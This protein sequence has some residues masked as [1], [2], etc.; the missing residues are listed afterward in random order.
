MKKRHLLTLVIPFVC[1]PLFSDDMPLNNDP[2][3]PPICDECPTESCPQPDPAM[4]CPVPCNRAITFEAGPRVCCGAD[5]F[6]T[7]D[8]LWWKAE[9]DGLAYA[10]T[11][12]SPQNATASV[13]KEGSVRHPDLGWEPGFRAGLGWNTC[14]DGWDLFAEYTWFQSNGNKDSVTNPADP[15]NQLVSYWGLGSSGIGNSTNLPPNFAISSANSDWTAHVNVIDL[16]LGRS[17]FVGEK[18]TFRPHAG[19]RGSWQSQQYNVTYNIDTTPTDRITYKMDQ[20]QDFWG[21]GLKF[22]LDTYWLFCRTFGLVADFSFSVLSSN[23]DVVRRDRRIVT[24][25]LIVTSDLL[26]LNAQNDYNTLKGVA[27]LFLGLRGDWWT[28][29]QGLHFMLQAGW[30]EEQWISFNNYLRI[31]EAAHGDLSLQGLTVKFRVDF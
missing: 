13:S 25:E 15:N 31:E 16:E 10:S 29:N 19:L 9:Q 26:L 24:D 5:L 22:G 4:G 21:V 12:S 14:Y 18:L 20:K 1:H 27:D 30:E 3:A 7:A 23:F 2:C 28:C 6:V 8:F 17:Y 11:G